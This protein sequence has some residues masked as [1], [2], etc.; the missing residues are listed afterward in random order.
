[1]SPAR[2]SNRNRAQSRFQERGLATPRRAD[3]I[4]RKNTP[5]RQFA[6]SRIGNFVIRIE[7]PLHDRQPD[8]SRVVVH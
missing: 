5:A 3:E 8:S 4:D 1:V 7:D 6:P 2:T